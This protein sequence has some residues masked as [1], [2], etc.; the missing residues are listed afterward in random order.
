MYWEGKKSWK[1][2]RI[3]W[4][5]KATFSCGAQDPFRADLLC[6]KFRLK[7][8]LRSSFYMFKN[9]DS[10]SVHPKWEHTSR[11][12]IIHHTADKR[13][14]HFPP[15]L[16]AWPGTRNANT[17]VEEILGFGC[18]QQMTRLTLEE[19]AQPAVVKAGLDPSL[20]GCLGPTESFFPSDVPTRR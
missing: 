14:Q 4:T 20:V 6:S 19:V 12:T 9:S 1:A 16:L 11:T 7:S 3:F 17:S 15:C 2:S 10:D 5:F 18:M 8:N 13:R